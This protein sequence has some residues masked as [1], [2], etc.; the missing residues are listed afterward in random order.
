VLERCLD[1]W[2]DLPAGLERSDAGNPLQD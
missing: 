2:G 1:R